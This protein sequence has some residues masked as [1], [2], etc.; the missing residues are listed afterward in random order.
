MPGWRK[1]RTTTQKTGVATEGA[2]QAC[3]QLT[4]HVEQ[5]CNPEL[6]LLNQ[7]LALQRGHAEASHLLSHSSAAGEKLLLLLSEREE[8]LPHVLHLH[9]DPIVIAISQRRKG[10]TS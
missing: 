4:V 1:S 5:T 10:A 7:Q 8:A 6:L 3:C 2:A 9:G